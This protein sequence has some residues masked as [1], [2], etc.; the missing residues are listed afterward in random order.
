MSR[1]ILSVPAVHIHR[2]LLLDGFLS[3][4]LCTMWY[5][6]QLEYDMGGALVDVGSKAPAFLP[7][8]VSR[9]Q[10]MQIVHGQTSLCPKSESQLFLIDASA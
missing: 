10:T 4:C 5:A 6:V 7:G 9:R 2:S 3:L 1:C 8:R